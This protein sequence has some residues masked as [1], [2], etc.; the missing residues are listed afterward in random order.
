MQ[1][2]RRCPQQLHGQEPRAHRRGHWAR[3]TSVHSSITSPWP[4]SLEP[5]EAVLAGRSSTKPVLA[6]EQQPAASHSDTSP[7]WATTDKPIKAETKCHT[8][9]MPFTEA[10]ST[11]EKSRERRVREGVGGDPGAAYQT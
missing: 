6:S 7:T 2:N 11:T 10:M 5:P 8:Q 3:A 1:L 4:G 9:K